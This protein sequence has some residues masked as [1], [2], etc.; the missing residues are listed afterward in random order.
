MFGEFAFI[1]HQVIVIGQ[2]ITFFEKRFY[3][4]SVLRGVFLL[5]FTLSIT[6]SLSFFTVQVLTLLPDFLNILVISII[7]SMFIAHNMLRS[8]VL[9]VITAEDKRHAISMLV[10]RDTKDLSESDIHKAAIETY[11]ENLSDGVIAALLFLLLFGLPGI[12]FYKTVNT[13][14]SMVGYRNEKYEN[15]VK[16]A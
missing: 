2:F 13:L 6:L 15:Y 7:A 5:L 16:R 12:V 4:D 14:D 11:G 8:A 3:K 1:K 10:S 9:G